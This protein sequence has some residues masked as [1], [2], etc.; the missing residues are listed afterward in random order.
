[1]T[2]RYPPY[3]RCAEFTP[4]GVSIVETEL[5]HVSV[6][7]DVV[8]PFHACFSGRTCRDHGLCLHEVLETNDLRL[9]ETRLEVGVDHPRRLGRCVPDVD[10]PGPC[11]L[12]ARREEGLQAQGGEP[13]VDQFLK[14]RFL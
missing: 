10:G 5:D 8:L 4:L 13:D 2:R 14:A 6:T 11:L 7:H 12:G 9:N 3:P 1:M